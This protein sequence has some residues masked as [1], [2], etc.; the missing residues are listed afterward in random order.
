MP[1]AGLPKTSRS[2]VCTRRRLGSR[3]REEL[4]HVERR[5]VYVTHLEQRRPGYIT[6]LDAPVGLFDDVARARTAGDVAVN[7]F[8]DGLT[9]VVD[10]NIFDAEPDALREWTLIT[11]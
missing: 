11:G 5:S 4:Q 3:H 6:D 8:S 10:S 2:R 9:M 7:V 1:Y